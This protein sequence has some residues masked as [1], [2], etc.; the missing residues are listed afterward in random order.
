MCRGAREISKLKTEKI[1]P[2]I[3]ACV[4]SYKL[5]MEMQKHFVHEHSKDSNS[6]MP[7]V[8]SLINAPRVYSID[9]PMCRWS[10][11]TRGSK[12]KTEFMRKRTRWITS[13]KEIAEVLRGDVTRDLFT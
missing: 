3:G 2:Q 6:W 13:S 4:Q 9:G 12:D 5:Q 11:R 7:E 1:E 10:L 8:Q